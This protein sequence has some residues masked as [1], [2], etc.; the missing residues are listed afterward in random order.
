MATITVDPEE[1]RAV[2]DVCK[3]MVDEAEWNRP[4][5]ETGGPFVYYI[6]AER[7]SGSAIEDNLKSHLF[8]PS[9]DG[10]HEWLTLIF[11]EP[12]GWNLV[13]RDAADDSEVVSEGLTVT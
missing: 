11:D 4:P 5:N 13:L 1:P 2:D 12:G 8:T 10:K 3:I 9:H 7:P 6:E